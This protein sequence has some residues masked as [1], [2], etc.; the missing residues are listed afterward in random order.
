MLPKNISRRAE[1]RTKVLTGGLRLI[2]ITQKNW[3]YSK[4]FPNIELMWIIAVFYS[5]INVQFVS[6]SFSD[7]VLFYRPMQV[8]GHS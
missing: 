5:K 2:R 4:N 8:P 6:Y 7:L 3:V 1:Q